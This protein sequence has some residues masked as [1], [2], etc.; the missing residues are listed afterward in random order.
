[1][2]LQFNRLNQIRRGVEAVQP[3][4]PVLPGGIF[5][6]WDRVA[7]AAGDDIL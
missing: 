3:V 5:G 6:L 7:P 4:E 2:A 1:M